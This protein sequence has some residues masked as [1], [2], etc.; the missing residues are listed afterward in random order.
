M[1]L[2]IFLILCVLPTLCIA[3]PIFDTVSGEEITTGFVRHESANQVT[4]H[5]ITPTQPL[6]MHNATGTIYLRIFAK[7]TYDYI[8]YGPW[9]DQ[10][11]AHPIGLVHGSVQ[12]IQENYVRDATIRISCPTT[13]Q[14]LKTDLFGGFRAFVPPGTCTIAASN[15]REIGVAEVPVSKGSVTQLTLLLN[16]KAQESTSWHLYSVLVLALLVLVV[17]FI[18]T[19][20]KSSSKVVRKKKKEQ[21]IVSAVKS[22]LT[23]KEHLIV[24]ELLL[25]EGTMTITELRQVTKIP[26]TSL[27]RTIQGLERRNILLR[28]EN[29]GKK[30]VK[31]L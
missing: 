27:I 22:A 31:L 20:K 1:L 17:L 13:S 14:E 6:N 19:R 26:R 24:D 2:R 12:D 7:E 11:L 21:Y 25:R 28:V 5:I 30:S 15:G 29:H 10:I 23:V 16:K 8:S 18:Q 4:T 9:P 3:Q